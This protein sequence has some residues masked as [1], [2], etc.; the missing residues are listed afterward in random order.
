M[1]KLGRM[2][3]DVDPNS[4]TVLKKHHG[5]VRTLKTAAVSYP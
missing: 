3:S 2:E 5:P 4:V 1:S